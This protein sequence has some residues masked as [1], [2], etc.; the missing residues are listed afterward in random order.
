MIRIKLLSLLLVAV[1]VLSACATSNLGETE[2]TTPSTT[3]TTAPTTIT[4]QPT[5]PPI[6]TPAEV[7]DG[8]YTVIDENKSDWH[9]DVKIESFFYQYWHKNYYQSSSVKILHTT[10]AGEENTNYVSYNADK[11]NFT[12]TVNGVGQTYEHMIYTSV[13]GQPEDDFDLLHILLVSDD[14]DA[15]YLDT[16][17]KE[18]PT[19][20]IVY[21][22]FVT[23]DKSLDS[24][25]D[26]P[27]IVKQ[28]GIE[29][30]EL[31]YMTYLK[32][33]YF[34]E[35][36]FENTNPRSPNKVTTVHRFDY[37]GNLLCS[38]ELPGYYPN[39][40]YAELSDGGFL[41][42]F[43]NSFESKVRYSLARYDSDGKQLWIH[44]FS[45]PSVVDFHI[46]N[47]VIYCF[48]RSDTRD[49]T[50]TTLSLDGEILSEKIILNGS[51]SFLH[52]IPEED[53]FKIYAN[54]Y[55]ETDD[56]P[57]HKFCVWFDLELNVVKHEKED[58]SYNLY[59]K[60][61]LNGK[62]VFSDDPIFNY[63]ASE[64]FPENVSGKDEN[65]FSPIHIFSYQD[66]YIIVR[67]H[68]MDWCSF[69]DNNFVFYFEDIYTYYDSNCV[70]Q[71]QY[72]TPI[73]L[74]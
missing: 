47:D 19:A 4:T 22:R 68:R 23:L 58:R 54:N 7:I 16:L 6:P 69:T 14:P 57:Y 42:S 65:V 9:P 45:T 44:D 33:S 11:K 66:G 72:V 74:A 1:M 10:A 31:G 64:T 38:V 71:C 12:F 27:T 49:I 8:T 20:A 5:E 70:P 61:Y 2:S 3:Q 18:N 30:R 32:D 48:G 46:V 56:M 55:G 34:M 63:H 52:V 51:Y 28:E 26:I 40:D 21:A 15:T 35:D 53:G 67:T 43:Y 36:I 62:P 25:G 29:L 24:Y 17:D 50:A 59:P 39:L 60:G 37:D 41:M 13:S 73:Y